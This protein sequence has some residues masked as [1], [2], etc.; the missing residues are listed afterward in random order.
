MKYQSKVFTIRPG[1][2]TTGVADSPTELLG[3]EVRSMILVRTDR[4]AAL[5]L[6]L[7]QRYAITG[8]VLAVGSARNMADYASGRA[9]RCR[10]RSDRRW[11]RE[12][13][14]ALAA[15][16]PRVGERFVV[17]RHSLTDARQLS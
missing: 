6:L 9:L 16:H 14:K 5:V 3:V 15:A 13:A 7:D 12:C 4:P 2:A 17:D 11:Y 1:D 10:S 8:E